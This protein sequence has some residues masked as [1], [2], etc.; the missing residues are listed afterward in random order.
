MITN[1]K[2]VGWVPAHS[3]DPAVG[4]PIGGVDPGH[5]TPDGT[6]LP[7]D[8]PVRPLGVSGEICWFVDPTGQVRDLKPPM[9]KMHL[10]MLFAGRTGY[11]SWAWPA[12]GKEGHRW[13]CG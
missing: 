4:A 2:P 13:I 5:W 9:G 11:L 1:A 12:L 6:G 7:A 3:D 10:L 8:C